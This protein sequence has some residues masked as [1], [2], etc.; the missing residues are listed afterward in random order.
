MT[1]RKLPLGLVSGI[2]M[3]GMSHLLIARWQCSSNETLGRIVEHLS[4]D[5][6]G[7]LG[8]VPPVKFKHCL[9]S[10]VGST[11]GGIAWTTSVGCTATGINGDVM[12]FAVQAIPRSNQNGFGTSPAARASAPTAN[13]SS[14]PT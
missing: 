9:E 13:P 11:E 5:A 10:V 2:A 1:N 4:G 3:D 7:E 14:S 12:R 8:R 6:T